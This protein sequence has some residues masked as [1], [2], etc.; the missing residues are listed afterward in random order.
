M[1]TAHSRYKDIELM[2]LD[3]V[4]RSGQ[5]ITDII[6]PKYTVMQQEF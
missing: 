2:T 6:N 4:W 3:I 5:K 1:K